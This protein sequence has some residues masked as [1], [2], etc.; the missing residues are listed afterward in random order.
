MKITD[1]NKMLIYHFSDNSSKC[2]L[3]SSAVVS[4]GISFSLISSESGFECMRIPV[5]Y[6]EMIENVRASISQNPLLSVRKRSQ[7]HNNNIK[8]IFR[9]DLLLMTC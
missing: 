6:D 2:W 5:R 8:T 1:S 4:C 9:E 7:A 3:V